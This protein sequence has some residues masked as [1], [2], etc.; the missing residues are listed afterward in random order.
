MITDELLSYINKQLEDGFTKDQIKETLT[1]SGWTIKDA[2]EAF[3]VVDN[4]SKKEVG[5]IGGE[6]VKISSAVN[7]IQQP[8][9]NAKSIALQQSEVK[10]N[11][12]SSM[13][14]ILGIVLLLGAVGVYVYFIF[15]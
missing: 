7:Q 15:F 13:L 14:I 12:V 11:A 3:D 2:Q 5:G 1:S 10:S 4:S 8:I 6:D 9:A